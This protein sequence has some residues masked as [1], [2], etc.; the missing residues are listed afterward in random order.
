MKIYESMAAIMADAGAITKSK[1]NQMQGFMFRGIDD[2]YN[3]LHSLF[4]KHQ[5]LCVPVVEEYKHTDA[6]TTKNG[7]MQTRAI[8]KMGYKFI[9]SDGSEVVASILGEGIDSGDKSTAKAMS[10][11]HKYLLLQTFLIPTEDLVDGDAESP[12]VHKDKVAID[13]MIAMHKEGMK[14]ASPSRKIVLESLVTDL[15]Q[16][17]NPP[18]V[19]DQ[20]DW[21]MFSFS[22][23]NLRPE[24]PLYGKTLGDLFFDSPKEYADDVYEYVRSKF[25][26][27]FEDQI[28]RSTDANKLYTEN[29]MHLYN[30][31]LKARKHLD[32]R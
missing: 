18:P 13:G 11:A 26:K 5:V 28:A 31:C 32:Q 27:R 23:K 24:S 12:V 9:A 10:V 30:A 4:A 25:M 7:T 16:K 2:V 3:S 17:L 20:T 19:V 22:G 6:G 21:K 1:K 14:D 15:E 8:V 29:D